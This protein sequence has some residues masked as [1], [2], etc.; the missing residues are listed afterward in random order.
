MADQPSLQRP[1]TPEQQENREAMAGAAA[2]IFAG[3]GCVG[4][5]LIMAIVL[6][7]LVVIA[8][9]LGAFAEPTGTPPP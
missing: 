6:I 4:F 5:A 9:V 3:L 2:G 7:A 1:R 8:W